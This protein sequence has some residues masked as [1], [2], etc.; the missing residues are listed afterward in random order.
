MNPTIKLAAEFC[1]ETPA[2]KSNLKFTFSE[3]A[4]AF[5]ELLQRQ[6]MQT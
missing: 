6:E 1:Y 2:M 5:L 3:K 4:L